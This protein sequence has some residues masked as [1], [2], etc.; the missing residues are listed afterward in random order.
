MSSISLFIIIVAGVIAVF[1]F[2]AALA[3]GVRARR[4]EENFI[5][6]PE[7]MKKRAPA[8]FDFSAPAKAYS[9]WLR[10]KEDERTSAAAPESAPEWMRGME[11]VAPGS[12]GESERVPI[13]AGPV[14][15]L[16]DFLHNLFPQLAA[17]KELAHLIRDAES[18]DADAGSVEERREAVLKAVEAMI[19][20]RPDAAFL[21]QMRDQLRARLDREEE[22]ADGGRIQ[23]FQVAGRTVIRTGGVEYASPEE[24]P[25][26][27]LAREARRMLEPA[28]TQSASFFDDR[29]QIVSSGGKK[30]LLVDGIEY[31]NLEDINNPAIREH[32]RRILS[33]Y[34]DRRSP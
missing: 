25:D 23:A 31:A 9:D 26:P 19:E 20:K 27:D 7:N 3:W 5:P 33:E 12:S 11:P 21:R 34:K 15:P 1:L 30:I 13:G 24:I 16:G 32:A 2:L 22:S 18:G 28:K 29:M 4:G 10:E 6:A 8:G 17:V 14:S